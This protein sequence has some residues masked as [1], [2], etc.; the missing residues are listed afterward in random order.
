MSNQTASVKLK[1]A[2]GKIVGGQLTY[3]AESPWRMALAVP[4]AMDLQCEER[5]LFECMLVLRRRL[6]DQSW[7]LLCNGARKDV[8]PSGMSREMSGGLIAYRHQDGR[9]PTRGDALN[10]V[11]Y[12]APELVGTIDEQK[13]HL[14]WWLQSQR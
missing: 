2:D 1:D 13:Q 11:E 12:A 5:D 6:Q 9:K 7:T 14:A 3:S 8:H 10:I 4:G